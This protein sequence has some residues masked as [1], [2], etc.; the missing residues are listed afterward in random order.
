MIYALAAAFF[1]AINIPC[2]K[3]LLDRIPPTFMAGFLYLG[4]GVGIGIL[5]LFR[6]KYESSDEQ[7]RKS[8]LT[9]TV[10]MVVLDIAAPILLMTG[11][12]LGTASNASL[13][14]NFEIVA[15]TLIAIIIFNEKVSARLWIAVI[16]ITASSMLLSFEGG[17]M[18]F[19]VGSLF[20]LGATVCW[21][22]ENNCT[23]R[24]SGKSTYQ[25][26]TIKGLCSGIGSLAVAFILKELPPSAGY[27]LL[28]M[29]L[30]FVAYG[31]SIFAYIR[32]QKQ[33]GAAKTSAYYAAAPFIGVLLSFI[34]LR[35]Q[36]TA[37]YLLALVIMLLGTGIIVYDTL[38]YS[39]EHEHRH[40]L[41]HT[42]NGITHTHIITH[43]HEHDHILRSG[44]HTH[45]HSRSEL[46]KTAS[47][48][49]FPKIEKISFLGNRIDRQYIII[50]GRN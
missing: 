18:S 4:A 28:T 20:V 11:I 38:L 37:S 30:G 7:L 8:D 9:Y 39:H 40:I 45:T 47:G 25:I 49:L 27:A 31:L 21:G 41:V 14:G 32:A 23:R 13:L 19:S 6:R 22:L 35:E 10:G 12:E 5:Y 2:S 15:T 43:T 16:F 34:L 44:V 48:F 24:I 36:I 17:G 33:L 1:Y 42:H 29:L 26:V 50:I 3:I 46:E